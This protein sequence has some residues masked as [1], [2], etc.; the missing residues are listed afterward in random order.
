MFPCID[1]TAFMFNKVKTKIKRD[2]NKNECHKCYKCKKC[3]DNLDYLKKCKNKKCFKNDNICIFK[4]TR[5]NFISSTL[6]ISTSTE[7][8]WINFKINIYTLLNNYFIV[9][10][11]KLNKIN[12]IYTKLLK[13]KYCACCDTISLYL[14]YNLSPGELYDKKCNS[15]CCNNCN[16]DNNDNKQCI[17][18]PY[19]QKNKLESTIYTSVKFFYDDDYLCNN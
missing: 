9:T 5:D 2:K 14:K 6:A 1:T 10:L 8:S 19:N 7:E 3:I 18:L 4:L 13:I 11:T 12:S 17:I 15:S 16:N